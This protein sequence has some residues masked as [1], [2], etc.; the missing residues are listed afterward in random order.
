[1]S[2]SPR[3][4]LWPVLLA[5]LAVLGVAAFIA[6]RYVS[7]TSAQLARLEGLEREN[8]Q[9]RANSEQLAQEADALRRDLAALEAGSPRVETSREPAIPSKMVEQAELLFQFRDKLAGA[10]AA[11][12][13]L[14]DRIHE[15]ETA[16]QRGV[17]ENKR[18]AASEADLK[19]QI[20]SS[21]RVL[22]AIKDE[23]QGKEQRLAQLEAA[24]K[25]IRE[26]NRANASRLNQIST[27]VRDLEEINRRRE[28]YVTAMFRRYKDITEQYQALSGQLDNPPP[29]IA[30][31]QESIAMAEEDMRQLASL[32]AQAARIAQR[33]A[34]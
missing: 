4:P 16:M 12:A 3:I 2:K 13:A 24:N 19:N 8:R 25:T 14:Q 29:G 1:M 26:E 23:L 31:I 11:I 9:L 5:M 34:K 15:L 21:T 10:N 27:L 22:S 7:A 18:L 20:A 32:N 30:R 33:I 28:S 6:V 17:E